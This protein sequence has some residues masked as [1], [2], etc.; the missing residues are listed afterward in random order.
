VPWGEQFNSRILAHGWPPLFL[1]AKMD[2]EHRADGA[3]TGPELRVR[4]EWL[5]LWGR[6]EAQHNKITNR[7]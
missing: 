3:L 6:W 7:A 5:H 4:K 1:W 2:L